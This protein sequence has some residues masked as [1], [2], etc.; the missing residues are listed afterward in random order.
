MQDTADKSLW[1]IKGHYPMQTNNFS[2]L[3][4]GHCAMLDNLEKQKG[5]FLHY[6]QFQ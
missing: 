3:F 6:F 2:I 5:T 4:K 1:N